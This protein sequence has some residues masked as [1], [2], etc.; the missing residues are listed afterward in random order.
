VTQLD[1]FFDSRAVMLANEVAD[2]L[3][4]RD[5]Q[6][7]GS[8]LAALEREDAAHPAAAALRVLVQFASDWDLPAEQP[9]D[10]ARAAARLEEH[11][12]PGA[13]H[14]LKERA[15]A[16]VRPYYLELAATAARLPYDPGYPRA[17]PAFLLQQ[18]GDFAASE[19]AVLKMPAW[20]RTPDALRWLTLARH[21]LRGLAVARATL[22][23]LCWSAPAR[24]AG[25]VGELA[26]EA[27]QRDWDAF[28]A[29]DWSATPDPEVPAWFAA[30]YLIQH[31]AA[32]GDLELASCCP[33]AASDAARLVARILDRER[34]GSST[35]LVHL[36]R[37]L[38]DLNGDLFALYMQRRTVFHR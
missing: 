25:L 6:G 9:S 11:I 26:D 16:F 1:L 31:P 34:E 20:K 17:H 21:R 14:L 33:G 38:R 27:L 24:A 19:R 3:V 36:R 32:A 30:W 7:A 29:S 23:A 2:R 10:I 35:A 15:R 22:F 28:V 37:R 13:A 5:A 12:A 4:A 18:A 8:A